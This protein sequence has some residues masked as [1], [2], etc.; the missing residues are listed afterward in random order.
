MEK[1]PKATHEGKLTLGE[2]V[3]NCAVLE[4]GTRLLTA[5]SVFEAFDRPRKGKSKADQRVAGMPSFVDAQNLQLF[6]SE[7]LIEW[8]KPVTYITKNGTKASGY[9][10]KIL[11][12]LC[13]VYLDARAANSLTASQQPIARASEILLIGLS[14]IGILALVDEATGYQYDRERDELQKI[15][16]AYISEELIPWQRRFPD[17]FYREIFRLNGWDFTVKGIKQRP[18]VVGRWTNDL[19]YKQ[20]PKGVLDELKKKTPK[21]EA[22]NYTARFFQSLTPDVGDPSLQAQINSVI[23]LF[24]ISDTWQDFTARFN[25]LVQRRSGQIDINFNTQKGPETSNSG[26][27]DQTLKGLLNVPPPKKD[28]DGPDDDKENEDDDDAVV[29]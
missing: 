29:V 3:M 17:L 24:Q 20:L 5:T 19:I 15:L 26:D 2:K 12:A 1:L 14:N 21:S 9:N 16:K 7:E 6:V 4:D 13:K 25:K 8:T 27:F 23:T 11:P 10:A 22:G 28:E 18:G